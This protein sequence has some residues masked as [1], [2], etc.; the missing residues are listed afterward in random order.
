[1]KIFFNLKSS[2]NL[3]KINVNREINNIAKNDWPYL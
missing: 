2:E 1:M 3:E